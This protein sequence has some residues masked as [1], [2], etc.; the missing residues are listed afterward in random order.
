MLRSVSA[1]LTTLGVLLALIGTGSAAFVGPDDTLMVG[2]KQVPERAAGLAVRTHPEIT[3]FVNIDLLVRAEA[4]GGVFLASS[5]RVDTQ[6]LLSGRRYFEITRMALNDVG[7]V[8]TKGPRATHRRLRPDRITGW[9][10]QAEGDAEAELVV[11]LDGTPLDVVAVPRQGDAL[12]TFAIGAHVAGAFVI[13]VV[14]ALTGLGMVLVGWALRR[15]ARR[16]AG[17]GGG[18][19]GPGGDDA[20]GDDGAGADDGTEGDDDAGG[21]R[22]PLALPKYPRALPASAAVPTPGPSPS[23]SVS[24]TPP[25]DEGLTPPGPRWDKRRI[26][27]LAVLVP[28]SLLLHGCAVPG[29]APATTDEV[30]RTGMLLGEAQQFDADATQV[31]APEFAAYPMWALVAT[32]A[33]TRVRLV[34]RE[35][36]AA[37]WRTEAQV[38]VRGPLPATVE[39]AI[40]PNASLVRRAD[41]VA[42]TVGLWWSSGEAPGLQLDRRTRR[43]RDAL[44]ASGVN[45]RALWA[46]DP[47]TGTPRVRLVE[48][49]GGHLAVVRHTL[50]TPAPR[51]LTTIVVFPTAGRPRVLGSTLVEVP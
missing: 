25:P 48:V 33:P 34:T 6:S 3:R 11:A 44:L 13:Q 43:T 28:L 32:A 39:R 2:E 45:P 7:G 23:P 5:H 42:A 31:F 24:V 51:R 18:S 4:E 26:V 30:T 46:L 22:T 16:R 19:G 20:R 9:I 29:Q 15:V 47:P 8:V 14:V 41:E 40:D 38:R 21:T 36:F 10:N 27:L 49:A 17:R 35:A 1:F 37:P 50:M 12:V